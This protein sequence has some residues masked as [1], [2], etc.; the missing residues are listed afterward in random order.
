MIPIF[1]RNPL[2]LYSRRIVIE[3]DDTQ[4]VYDF[5]DSKQNHLLTEVIDTRPNDRNV[6]IQIALGLLQASRDELYSFRDGQ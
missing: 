3:N 6:S 4:R 2:C 1:N 5:Y